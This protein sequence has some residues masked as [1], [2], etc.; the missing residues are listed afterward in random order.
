MTP[1]VHL[2]L[3]DGLA[4]WEPAYALPALRQSGYDV[5]TVGFTPD[6]VI[7]LSGLRVTP[8]IQWDELTDSKLVV[9]P[10]SDGWSRNEYPVEKFQHKLASLLSAKVPVAAICG[11]T[12]AVARAGAFEGRQH[13]SNDQGWL[14][15]EAP[16]YSGADGY[17]KD[18]LAVRDRGLISA[19][20]SAPVEFAREIIAE[21]DA[22]PKEKLE[23]WFA[24][25][26]TGR[27]P[28]SVDANRFF[29]S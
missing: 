16:D 23:I 20:G 19:A 22:M 8:D 13:T 24:L 5:I 4:D 1:A 12:V 27:L 2:V 10:G 6:P 9:L 26:K 14:Q 11:A 7:T 29:G 17:R 25:F 18:E 3:I 28:A 15:H 21:L